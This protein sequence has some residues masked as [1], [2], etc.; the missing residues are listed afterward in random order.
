M[1]E[2]SISPFLEIHYHMAESSIV[3]ILRNAY[4]PPSQINRKVYHLSMSKIIY[5]RLY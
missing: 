4:I 5:M 1:T 3:R 2:S